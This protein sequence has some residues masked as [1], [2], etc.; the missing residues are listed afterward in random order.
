MCADHPSAAPPL[1]RR[2]SWLQRALLA[3]VHFYRRYVSPLTPPVCRFEPSCS[4]YMVGCI[5]EWGAFG[6]WLGARRI[7]RC[8]PFF[9]GGYDPVPRK[10]G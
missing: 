10:P 7:F 9:P 6:V 3:P 2:L 1:T 5:E 8:Q 4:A